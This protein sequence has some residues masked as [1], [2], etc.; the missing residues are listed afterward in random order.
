MGTIWGRNSFAAVSVAAL[1]LA[2]V[3]CSGDGSKKHIA[4][5]DPF[6]GFQVTEG[7][8]GGASYPIKALAGQSSVSRVQP[9]VLVS[10]SAVARNP[11][12]VGQSPTFVVTVRAENPTGDFATAPDFSLWCG[13]LGYGYLDA[14]S[15]YASFSAHELAAG[16]TY[17]GNIAFAEVEQTANCDEPSL[18]AT[19]D[20]NESDLTN[21]VRWAF[22]FPPDS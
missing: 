22:R 13:D 14:L 18:Y 8:I 3:A 21:A 2:A 15:T 17:E 11:G 12:T 16:A 7:T 5:G 9:T 19:A 6:P 1:A 4:S 20:G 10:L